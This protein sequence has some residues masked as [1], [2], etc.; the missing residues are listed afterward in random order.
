M[1][2]KKVLLNSLFIICLVSITGCVESSDSSTSE[3]STTSET[4]TS[5]T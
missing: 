2:I 3:T 5:A 1:T 4:T